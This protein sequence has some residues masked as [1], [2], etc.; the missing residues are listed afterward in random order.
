[1]ARRTE[2]GAFRLSSATS[3]RERMNAAGKW[4]TAQGADWLSLQFVPYGFHPKGVVTGLGERLAPLAKVADNTHLMLHELWIGAESGA[5]LRHRLV[6]WAQRRAVTSLVRRL[7]PRLVHTS[8]EAYR[9]LSAQSGIAAQLLPLCGNIPVV[10]GIDP[11]WLEEAWLRAGVPADF[12]RPRERC[13]WF[14]LFGSIHPEWSCEPL[15]GY[16]ASAARREGRRVLIGSIGRQGAGR[17]LWLDL[18]R[19]YGFE[20]C[21]LGE[22]CPEEVSAFLQGI[23]FGIATTPWQ[24]VGKSGTAAAM[25]E[26][27]LPVIVSRDDVRLRT[28]ANPTTGTDPLLYKMDAQL[29]HWLLHAKKRAPAPNNL[30]TLANRFVHD[31]K[32]VS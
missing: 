4:L 8:N 20:L 21:A 25:L 14:G 17:S 30:A 9:H 22:R 1:M 23:D 2:V 12:V 13:W 5:S 10:D 27:G 29:P 24:L 32:A 16:I 7:A 6:G 19:R 18:P 15:F 28:S 31:L 11:C 26:H 3:W